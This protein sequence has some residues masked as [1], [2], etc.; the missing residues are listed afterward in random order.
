ML[1]SIASLDRGQ[2]PDDIF[3]HSRMSFGD[4]IE[5]L[6]KYLLRGIYGFLVVL[7][8]GVILD[9]VG[10]SLDNPYIGLGRPMLQVIVEPA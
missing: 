8:G 4:H 10:A 6:R 2:T 1:P 5:E 9:N 7:F 3:A